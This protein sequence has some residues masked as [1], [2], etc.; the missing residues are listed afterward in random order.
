MGDINWLWSVI[1]W[2]GLKLNNL[3]QA[4]QEYKD[5]SSPRKLPAKAE[6]K[7]ALIE[8]KLND[9]HVDLLDPELDFIPAML[10]SMHYPTGILMQREDNLLEWIFL[11]HRVEN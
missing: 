3:F 6:R 2:S 11:P 9:E 4:L 1:E 8:E 5:L 10:L 7:L